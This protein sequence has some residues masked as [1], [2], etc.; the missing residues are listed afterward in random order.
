MR[1][2]GDSFIFATVQDYRWCNKSMAV[3]S[4]VSTVSAILLNCC[5][6][7]VLE[8]TGLPLPTAGSSCLSLSIV[9]FVMAGKTVKR[10]RLSV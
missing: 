9:D 10:T 7:F 5:V 8:F 2:I 4:T 6:L 3:V 1:A